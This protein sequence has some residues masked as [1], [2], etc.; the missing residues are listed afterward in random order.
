MTILW[1]STNGVDYS[2]ADSAIVTETGVDYAFTKTFDAVGLTISYRFET[3]NTSGASSWCS[4]NEVATFVNYDNAIY[5]WL[6]EVAA[7]SWED[8]ACWSNSLN[9]ARLAYPSHQ[10]ATASFAL[11]DPATPVEATLGAS[12]RLRDCP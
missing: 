10:Y 3:I 1:T 11:L 6:P 9:D 4:T 8:A 2:L 7:G 12:H 5:Y